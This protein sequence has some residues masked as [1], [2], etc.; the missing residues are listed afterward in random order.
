MPIIS[1]NGADLYFETSGD[2]GEIILFAHHLLFD[3]R[4][5]KRE[6]DTLSLEYHCVAFDWRGQGRSE[7]TLGG[8]DLDALLVDVINLMDALE[9]EHAHWV[10]A[11]NSTASGVRLAAQFPD[12]IQSLFL[13]CPSIEAASLESLRFIEPIVY[14][15]FSKNKPSALKKLEALIFGEAF[16]AAPE[17]TKFVQEQMRRIGELDAEQLTRTS[18]PIFRRSDSM[19]YL[20]NV[21]CP[22]SLVSGALDPLVSKNEL[23]RVCETLTNVELTIMEGIGH[24]PNFEAP[25][26]FEALLRRHLNRARHT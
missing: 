17:N 25:I 7:K 4:M 13:M 14:D 21:H 5:F 20:P 8:Y 12:R 9:I 3:A 26:E 19:H 22:T 24:H 18:L 23:Q 16:R 15:E 11:S 2:D 10:G 6:V 1:V